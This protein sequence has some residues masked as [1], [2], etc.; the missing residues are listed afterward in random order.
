MDYLILSVMLGLFFALGLYVQRR[1]KLSFTSEQRGDLNVTV[2]VERVS[3]AGQR[4]YLCTRVTLHD[5]STDRLWLRDISLR[6][7][8]IDHGGLP[9][10]QRVTLDTYQLDPAQAQQQGGPRLVPL[11]DPQPL[12]TLVAGDQLLFAHPLNL[13]TRGPVLV[14]VMVLGVALLSGHSA[15]WSTALMLAGEAARPAVFGALPAGAERA[16]DVFS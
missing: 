3:C 11:Q 9:I 4:D 13:Q 1:K 15:R 8:P 2:A 16:A 14:E 7:M 12:V 5:N 10:T 6:L